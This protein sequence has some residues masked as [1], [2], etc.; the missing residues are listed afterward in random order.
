[1]LKKQRHTK[2]WLL[3]V[4]VSNSMLFGQTTIPSPNPNRNNSISIEQQNRETLK[5]LGYTPP[6]TQVEIR[7]KAEQQRKSANKVISKKEQHRNYV[8][9]VL[10][11]DDG[12]SKNPAKKYNGRFP[13]VDY[14][15]INYQ[16]GIPYFKKAFSEISKMLDSTQEIDLKKAIF[17]IE[18][19]VIK[20]EINYKDFEQKIDRLKELLQQI[21]KQEKINLDN[22]IGAHYAIQKLFSDTLHNKRTRKPFY[23]FE[24]DFN[25]IYGGSDPTQTLVSKLLYTGKGQCK[26]MPLLYSILAQELNA[27]SYLSFSPN[28]SYIKYKDNRGTWFNFETT[29]GTNTSDSWVIGSGFIKAEAIKSKIYTEPITTRQIVAHL[30]VELALEYQEQFGFDSEFMNQTLDKALENFP[31]DIFAWMMKANLKTAE[32][33]RSIASVGYPPINELSKY[34]K[35]EQ[36]FKEML[37]LYEKVDNL[38]YSKMPKKAYDDWLNSLEQE[39]NKQNS[40]NIKQA[41]LIKALD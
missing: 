22:D 33:E 35:Q 18:N 12:K 23:P 17:L 11:E 1:M 29:N 41:L 13:F 28:H 9:R 15:S 6:P 16:N 5:R 26:S 8:Y 30:L 32:F 10:T 31:N 21:A 27:E 2:T 19:T 36:L 40:K 3:C 7:T 39:K 37:A 34:P 24:Y 14:Q 4:F 20:D 25:D 38:G